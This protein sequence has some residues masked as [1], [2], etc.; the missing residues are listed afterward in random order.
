MMA[1]RNLCEV[2]DKLLPFVREGENCGDAADQLSKIAESAAFTAPEM[3]GVR[4]QAAQNVL[5]ENI[6]AD[7]PK[8][9]EIARIWNNTTDEPVENR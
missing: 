2:I 1:K 7:H 8:R 5:V 6:H 4:W 3:M 9:A